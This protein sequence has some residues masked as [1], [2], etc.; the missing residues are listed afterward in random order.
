MNRSPTTSG[1]IGD[2]RAHRANGIDSETEAVGKQN[3]VFDAFIIF[4]GRIHFDSFLVHDIVGLDTRQLTNPLHRSPLPGAVQVER[5]RGE[6]FLS[7][8]RL[9]KVILTCQLDQELRERMGDSEQ[10]HV[11]QDHTNRSRQ[12][13]LIADF[14]ASDSSLFVYRR[15]GVL[16]ARRLILLQPELSRLEREWKI[17]DRQCRSR[18]NSDDAEQTELGNRLQ[19]LLFEIDQK[20]EKYRTTPSF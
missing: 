15:F 11:I 10:Q 13:C 7:C 18:P 20:S 9:L 4:S 8:H 19:N 12:H 2:R 6:L 16:T 3:S 5:Y 17:L 1:I 14:I